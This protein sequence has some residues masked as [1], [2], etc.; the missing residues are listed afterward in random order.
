M[1]GDE[2]RPLV[3]LLAAAADDC[4]SCLD[5]D[6]MQSAL[7]ARPDS[8]IVYNQQVD[9]LAL[10]DSLS[11]PEDHVFVEIR[12]DTRG[13]SGLHA[14]RRRRPDYETLELIFQ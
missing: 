10:V 2:G 14:V 12:Q 9:A 5:A 11:V 4:E 7:Q 6:Q 3:G 8:V 1:P 13:V